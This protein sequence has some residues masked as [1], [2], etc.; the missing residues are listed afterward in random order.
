MRSA[1]ISDSGGRLCLVMGLGWLQDL[2][3]VADSYLGLSSA[4]GLARHSYN[5][6][7]TLAQFMAY[8]WHQENLNTG[9]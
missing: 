6:S 7:L 8:I 5:D 3:D 2:A 9:C 4:M 1:T